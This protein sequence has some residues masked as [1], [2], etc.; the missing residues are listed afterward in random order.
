MGSH[1]LRSGRRVFPQS[2]S[3][4]HNGLITHDTVA[5]QLRHCSNSSCYAYQ[6]HLVPLP[7]LWI[8]YYFL[9]FLCHDMHSRNRPGSSRKHSK[10]FREEYYQR[11]VDGQYTT[12][13]TCKESA[14]TVCFR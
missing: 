7:A 11:G 13:P 8:L 9:L 3:F 2:C 1:T 12:T 6:H 14:S 5:I 4:A 10:A